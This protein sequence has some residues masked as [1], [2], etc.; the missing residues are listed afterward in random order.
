MAK[1]KAQCKAA[2]GTWAK[3]E[4]AAGGETGGAAKAPPPA[5]KPAE[6]APAPTGEK[7]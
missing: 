2:K 4:P 3:D 5:E 1:T 6:K 7:K